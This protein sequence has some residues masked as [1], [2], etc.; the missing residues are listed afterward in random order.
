MHRRIYKIPSNYKI[1]K[2]TGSGTKRTQN[3]RKPF[4]EGKR[5][6]KLTAV[7]SE[8]EGEPLGNENMIAEIKTFIER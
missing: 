6:Q 5:G 3:G 2:I 8:T 1:D 7:G 4:P